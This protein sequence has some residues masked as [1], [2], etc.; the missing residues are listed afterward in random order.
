MAT[1]LT[2][3]YTRFTDK[4][5]R[6][7]AG[8]VV[9]T[10]E[11]NSL[12]PK[13]TYQDPLATI[14][15]LP[16][17][18]LDSTGRA[19]IYLLGDYRVQIYSNDG[20]LI[21]DNL[22]VDQGVSQTEFLEVNKTLIANVDSLEDLEE[23]SNVWD[24]RTIYVKDLGNYRY[25]AL[26]TSWVKAY[27][28]ADNVRYGSKTQKEVNDLVGNT[29]YAKPLG[30]EL[31]A[32]VM[33]E[34]GDIVKNT[35]ANNAGN[36]NNPSTANDGWVV[37][38]ATI[39]NT[40]QDLMDREK[41]RLG[42]VFYVK[43][44][45]QPNYALLTP[46]S[47]WGNFEVVQKGDL[48]VNDGTILRSSDADKVYVRV[49]SGDVDIAWF[50]AEI[51]KDAS[52][53]IEKA[54]LISKSVVIRGN[55]TLETICGIPD[56]NNYSDTVIRIRG[57][58]QATLTV[59]CPD[60]AVFTSAAAK[61]DPTNLSNLFT[62]KINVSGL[63]FIG[64]TIS[65]SVIFNGD[66]LYNMYI[67]H[68][69]FKGP[70]TIIKAYLKRL[71][72]KQYTQS[73]DISYNHLA[74]VHRVIETDRAYNFSF[75]FN[76]CENCTGGMYIGADD[77]YD[78]SGMSLSIFRNLWESSGLI[79]KSNG[80]IIAGSVS[81]N[82]FESNN[83]ADAAV[84]K[85]QVYIN[86]TGAG[87]GHSSGLVFD[88]NF[89]SGSAGVAGYVDVRLN[90]TPDIT[91]GNTKSA[92]SVPAVFIG[93]WSENEKLTDNPSAIL[94][95]NRVKNRA[96]MLNAYTAQE[97]RVSFFSGYLNKAVTTNP[98]RFMTIDTRPCLTNSALSANFKASM[99]VMLH[100]TTVGA[101][102]TATV[103]F[104]LDLMVFASY[105]TGTPPPKA[106]LKVSMSGFFQSSASDKITDTVNM[107]SVISTPT[108]SVIDNGDGTYHLDLSTFANYSAPNLGNIT[109]VRVTYNM[110]GS[111]YIPGG[112]SSFNL[113]GIS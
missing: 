54:L 62:G 12:I 98:V 102:N 99:D 73:T 18:V 17:V 44:Y 52:P 38:N 43:S 85:C 106:G 61:I 47:G 33:L 69:N 101:V 40:V 25:D 37:P 29:W 42:Q 7:L 70:L 88:S 89:F 103:G 31:N 79:L 111:G 63:N 5:N 95:G 87:A 112:Y 110:Q 11:P 72:S 6:V 9:K 13:I 50:G 76:A 55:Y 56:Q 105:G 8:G 90:N 49:W 68:N 71:A 4:C 34:N 24:G 92:L 97:A 67:H 58:N 27:Q 77:P 41:P 19:R 2:S 32:R 107:A 10:F 26:T 51:G 3:Q 60:G 28:D 74:N 14:P 81:K 94:I 80:G 86:R 22:Y 45:H 113:L 109:N 64:T 36:P 39:V 15:N 65:N 91:L 35:I 20:T 83:I 23:I 93:N 53:Y 84:E 96:L 59:N 1:A 48:V 78:P 100:F 104:K 75:E 46:F 66:R 108:L 82:Y 21:E 16:E 30:Y 57:E